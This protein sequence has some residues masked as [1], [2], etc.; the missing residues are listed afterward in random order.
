MHVTL[1]SIQE[2]A[3]DLRTIG[4]KPLMRDVTSKRKV[5]F[6]EADAFTRRLLIFRF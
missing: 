4:L 6:Y 5:I 3:L 2:K 1:G